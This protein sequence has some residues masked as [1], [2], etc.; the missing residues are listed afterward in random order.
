MGES[1][2]PH[3][4]AEPTK[5]C[6]GCGKTKPLSQFHR[7]K[8]NKVDG[9]GNRCKRCVAESWS[10]NHAEQQGRLIQIRE[11]NR[12]L[13]AIGYD[14]RHHAAPDFP[15]A[16]LPGNVGM[17]DQRFAGALA[18]V[19]KEIR[20]YQALRGKKCGPVRFKA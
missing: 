6:S 16:P 8:A 12:L 4:A 17:V 13:P 1:P 5:K 2:K 18:F 3:I 11:D 19:F 10:R 15:D 14:Y 7:N 9:H 20:G